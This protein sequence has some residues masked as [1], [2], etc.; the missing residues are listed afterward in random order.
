MCSFV[1]NIQNAIATLLCVSL[2]L[3]AFGWHFFPCLISRVKFPFAREALKIELAL[4]FFSLLFFPFQNASL[5]ITATESI[6]LD[7]RAV[8][9][10]SGPSIHVPSPPPP[11]TSP[12]QAQ[13]SSGLNLSVLHTSLSSPHTGLSSALSPATTAAAVKTTAQ[14]A[15]IDTD[16]KPINSILSSNQP[17]TSILQ[18]LSYQKKLLLQTQNLL[19]KQQLQQNFEIMPP[20]TPESPTEPAPRKRRRKREDPQS[21]LTNSEVSA[22]R[23]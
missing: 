9:L 18:S 5:T 20:P 6:Q 13:P 12:A 22:Q 8:S 19:S 21:C 2:A 7:G 4:N 10:G 14:D 11:S 15:T 23:L 1:A 3:S 16:P 17:D